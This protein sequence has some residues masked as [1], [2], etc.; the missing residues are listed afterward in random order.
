MGSTVSQRNPNIV[1]LLD[2]KKFH[3]NPDGTLTS[4]EGVTDRGEQCYFNLP[5]DMPA[6][7]RAMRLLDQEPT[8]PGRTPDVMNVLVGWTLELDLFTRG[9]KVYVRLGRDGTLK[10][11]AEDAEGMTKLAEWEMEK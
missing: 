7:L 8:P 6:Y 9:V 2:L 10:V 11:F 3:S 4:R 1:Q 5:F